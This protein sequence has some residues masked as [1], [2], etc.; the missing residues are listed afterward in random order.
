M[1]QVT[2]PLTTTAPS[3]VFGTHDSA[4]GIGG[5]RE[6]A[7][8]A[9]RNAITDERRRARMLVAQIDTGV[10]WSL[11]PG[12]WAHTDADWEILELGAGETIDVLEFSFP[13]ASTDWVMSHDLGTRPTVITVD[14]NG[15]AFEGNIHYAPGQVTVHYDVPGGVTG[16]ATL[17]RA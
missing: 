12:P 17:K 15:D 1:P 3:D 8:A 13:T 10:Y 2:G 16:F 5:L 7:N 14:E 6:V 9:A 11:K 4:Y